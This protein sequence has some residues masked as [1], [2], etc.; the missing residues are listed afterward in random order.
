[1]TSLAFPLLV[2]GAL[3][4][5]AG[6]A[7]ITLAPIMA[8]RVAASASKP[9]LERRGSGPERMR[10]LITS[11]RTERSRSRGL[12]STL[13]RTGF[14]LGVFSVLSLLSGAVAWA[15]GY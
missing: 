15:M 13:T 8:G 9:R 7:T 14:V 3:L 6:A 10:T 2:L 12:S 4:L 5:A 11:Q 1:M